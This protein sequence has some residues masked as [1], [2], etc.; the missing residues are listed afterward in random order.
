MQPI[1]CRFVHS[2]LVCD[3]PVPD[4]CVNLRGAE[5]CVAEALATHS[6]GYYAGAGP[7]PARA[8]AGDPAAARGDGLAL[9]LGLGLGLGGAQCRVPIC[10]VVTRA[11]VV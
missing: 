7:P 1:I 4:D 6:D 11:S 5:R 9:G 8:A 2:F 10:P 3:W